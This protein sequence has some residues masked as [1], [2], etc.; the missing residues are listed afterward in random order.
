MDC[1]KDDDDRKKMTVEQ[2]GLVSDATPVALKER[3]GQ[4]LQKIGEKRGGA[5]K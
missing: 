1:N 2:G 5:C 3:N 4:R